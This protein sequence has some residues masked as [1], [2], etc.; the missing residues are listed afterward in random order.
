M[1]E[2]VKTQEATLSV[3]ENRKD[4]LSVLQHSEQIIKQM[5]PEKPQWLTSY[6]SKSPL[7]D[8]SI[9]VQLLSG[10]GFTALFSSAVG[11]IAFFVYLFG[12]MA[13]ETVLLI[14]GIS[15][16]LPISLVTTLILAST[17]GG[18]N[19]RQP[20]RKFCAKIFSNK[21]ILDQLDSRV[22]EYEDYQKALQLHQLVIDKEKSKLEQMNVFK[23]LSSATEEHSM[24]E[25]GKH[26]IEA[27]EIPKSYEE[28]AVRMVD[29]LKTPDAS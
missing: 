14:A 23:Q 24:D 20:V 1:P 12:V 4:A 2:V 26:K 13:F 5:Q 21:K 7:Q 8:A 29:Y 11:G 6:N 22:K 28:L 16:L 19:T 17:Y 3:V 27:I 18:S 15:S 9:L 10:V 25:N